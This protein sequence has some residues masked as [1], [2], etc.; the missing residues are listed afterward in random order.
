M[1]AG[2]RILDKKAVD[3]CM[4]RLA[5]DILKRSRGLD[6]LAVIGIRR[7]GVP[8]AERVAARIK[9]LEG[10]APRTGALDITLY[11]DDLTLVAA[12]PVVSKT[13]ID[14]P[15]EGLRVVLCDDVLFTGRTVRAAM[16]ALLAI[17]RPARIELAVL[18]DRGFRELPVEANYVAERVETTINEV[19]KVH[20]AEIDGEDFV[21]VLTMEENVK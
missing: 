12:Q 2:R 20:L 11:R 5:R 9:E 1:G 19:V 7:R 18:V 16:D 4:D 15:V 8:I 21:E 17:G 10:H 14:Y 3:A 13:E 6:D